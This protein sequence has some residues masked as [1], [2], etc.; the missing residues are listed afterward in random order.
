MPAL[1]YRVTLTSNE[2]SRLKALLLEDKASGRQLARARILLKA[3]SGWIDDDIV[4]RLGVS[5]TMVA[6]TRRRCYELGAEAAL[7]ERRKIGTFRA[8]LSPEAAARVLELAR[9]EPPPERTHWSLR[10][11][12]EQAVELGLAESFSAEGIRVLLLR[13]APDWEGIRVPRRRS[14]LVRRSG[15]R[16][17]KSRSSHANTCQAEPARSGHGQ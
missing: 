1:I 8:K 15:L 3:A 10:L 16:P 14:P 6:N 17:A 5:R 7:K 4:R 2:R 9:S 13:L 11:L 12:A